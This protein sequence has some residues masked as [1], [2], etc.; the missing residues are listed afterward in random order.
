MKRMNIVAMALSLLVPWVVF[1]LD[2]AMLSFHMHYADPSLCQTLTIIQAVIMCILVLLAFGFS[3]R[4]RYLVSGADGS[5][6]D[7]SWLLF[8]AVSSLFAIAAAMYCG[9]R[10]FKLNSQVY[11]DIN[12]L[13]TYQGVDV[14]RMRGQELMDAGR[15]TF[16]EGTQVDL[17]R[18]MA[19][20]N[21]ETYCVAP[22]TI[23]GGGAAGAPPLAS[24]DFWAVGKDCCGAPASGPVDFRCGAFDNPRARG[25]FRALN[26][27][28]RAFYRLAVQQAQST[29]AI[30]AV[31]P[32]F[33]HWVA[34]PEA[35]SQSYLSS[36]HQVLLGGMFVFFGFQ[37]ALVYMASSVFKMFFGS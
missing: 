30:R 1:C 26:D 12:A 16:V 35:E 10:N 5:N 2:F 11:F 9:N 23:G 21:Q 8:V 31:H 6:A 18:S 28:D 34:D 24:Y 22:I 33:F 4:S 20:K 37:M 36:A 14:A 29:Y 32:L 13:N 27:Q 7:P 3:V 19:F 17:G 15:V 25:G